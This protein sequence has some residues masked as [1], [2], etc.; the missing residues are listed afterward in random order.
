MESNESRNGIAH[1]WSKVSK[2]GKIWQIN[3]TKHPDSAQMWNFVYFSSLLLVKPLL[4]PLTNTINF[5]LSE[6]WASHCLLQSINIACRMSSRLLCTWAEVKTD[7]ERLQNNW[8]R[9]PVPDQGQ[10]L[11]HYAEWHTNMHI[12]RVNLHALK[13]LK[14]TQLHHHYLQKVWKLIRT[15]VSLQSRSTMTILTVTRNF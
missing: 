10:V 9:V 8:V 1:P 11:M 15:N 5:E 14:D 4:C 6:R 13:I 12:L 3:T 2:W 7:S